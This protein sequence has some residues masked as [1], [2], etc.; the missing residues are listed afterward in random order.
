M[1]PL[2]KQFK[3][4]NVE[5]L[6]DTL[7]VL[8]VTI[9]KP[10]VSLCHRCHYHIPA[11]TYHK[12]NQLWLVKVCKTHG[13]SHHMIERD[14]EFYSRLVYTKN[15]FGFTK[16][17]V[18]TEVTDKC[19]ANCPHCYHIPNNK[20]DP[21][22]EQITSRIHT[23]CDDDTTIILAGAEPVLRYDIAELI[24]Y[25]HKTFPASNLAT[26]SNGIR[27]SDRKLVDTVIDAGLK[28]V[29]IGLNHPS[30]LNNNVI[31]DKQIRGI[32][33]CQEQGLPLYY[34][35]YTMSSISELFDILDEITKSSWNPKHFR[36]RY[37]SDIGRYPEQDRM[38]VSDIYKLI[39]QWCKTNGREFKDEIGDNNLYHTMVSVDGRLI[40]VIQWCDETDINM[41]ELRSGPYCDF[42]PDGITNFLHQVI[43][44]D[45]YKNKNIVLPDKPFARYLMNGEDNS[46]PLI[47]GDLR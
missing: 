10:T 21:T 1:I 6:L 4:E 25:I 2:V 7:D 3:K 30:Y 18:M 35:G 41:E 12:D 26:L 13:I 36:I 43:R 46:G 47:F 20:R 11:Y 40:R 29:M 23:W 5:K 19:N 34:V 27:F 9:L 42:V 37:G 14:Y 17:N 44:R 24:S 31:R 15:V 28:G 8:N 16:K 39:K 22:F 38:Y 33:N 32:A 45:V